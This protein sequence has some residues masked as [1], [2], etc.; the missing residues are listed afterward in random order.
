MAIPKS[1]KSKCGGNWSSV[2]ATPATTDAL[3]HGAPHFI[4]ITRISLATRLQRRLPTSPRLQFCEDHVGRFHISVD[5]PLGVNVDLGTR[6][7]HD[8]HHKSPIAKALRHQ[9]L[10]ESAIAPRSLGGLCALPVDRGLLELLEAPTPHRIACFYGTPGLASQNYIV[11]QAWRCNMFCFIA[12]LSMLSTL[13][14]SNATC[15]EGPLR[16]QENPPTNSEHLKIQPSL[17]RCNQKITQI[18]HDFFLRGR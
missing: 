5:H 7:V 11:L 1:A 16:C 8:R 18:P 17:N 12:S 4:W 10:V 13:G 14:K 6:R 15:P 9:E 2:S 3:K